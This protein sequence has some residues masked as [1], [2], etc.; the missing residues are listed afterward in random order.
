MPSGVVVRERSNPSMDEQPRYLVL[1]GS[2]KS[3]HDRSNPSMDVQ[4]Q[5]WTYCP[6]LVVRDRSN[7]SMDEQPGVVVRDRSSSGVDVQLWSQHRTSFLRVRNVGQYDLL[8]A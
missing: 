8:R 3:K 4:I 5:A 7:P 2:V 1:P 6:D